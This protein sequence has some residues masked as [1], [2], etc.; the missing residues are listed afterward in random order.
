[1]NVQERWV[2]GRLNF[3]LPVLE[4]IACDIRRDILTLLAH[5]GTG[6]TGGSL[7]GADFL[8]AILFHEA[9]VDPFT[10]TWKDRDFWHV[11]HGHVTPL[12]Y[13]AMGERGYFPLRDLLSFR[14]I[15]GHL[16]GHPSVKDT[17]GLEVSAGSL[18]QGLSVAV[19]AA[20]AAK[21]DRHPRRCFVCMGDGEQQEGSVWEAAMSA[22]HYKLDNLT[23][24]I[25][26][27]RMQIDGPTS[28]VL[29]V[30]PLDEKYRA[31]GWEV[32]VVDGHDLAALLDAFTEAKNVKGKPSV[33]LAQTVMGKGWPEIED[34]FTWHGKP[35]TIEQADR[36]LQGL[37]AN[38]GG[39]WAR[40][41][42]N[43][44][45]P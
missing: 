11:S 27:N 28:E 25:D 16:Q 45:K 32:F 34:N 22:A 23:A 31:F 26:V 33:L 24:V 14:T 21:M 19:G 10:P 36:A 38:Y 5:A 7:S 29:G 4:E 40:L 37:G 6:H 20:L 2:A 43:G 8:T 17:P 42:A 44:L 35:P 30:E 13:S 12:I 1:M 41:E 18:G 39:W 3:P 9:T 15:H